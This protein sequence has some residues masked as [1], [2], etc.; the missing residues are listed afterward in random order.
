MKAMRAGLVF[1]LNAMIE[2][3]EVH[4]AEKDEI[5][6]RVQ[7]VDIYYR[8]VGKVGSEDGETLKATKSRRDSIPLA[9]GARTEHVAQ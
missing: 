8:F 1:L 7:D 6:M 4:E 3:I 2:K 9:P 5:G